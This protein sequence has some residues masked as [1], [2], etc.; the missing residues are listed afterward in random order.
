VTGLLLLGGFVA[1]LAMGA[2]PPLASPRPPVSQKQSAARMKAAS[3]APKIEGNKIVF[4]NKS[5]KINSNGRLEIGVDGTKLASIFYY[6]NTNFHSWIVTHD[7]DL[8]FRNV[9]FKSD[10]VR[11]FYEYSGDFPLEKA[12]AAEMPLGNYRQSV[13]L[14]ADGRVKVDMSWN[15]PAGMEKALKK[16][17]FFMTIPKEKVWQEKVRVD[18]KPYAFPNQDQYGFFRASPPRKITLF[19][20]RPDKSFVIEPQV[21]ALGLGEVRTNPR[22]GGN[23]CIRLWADKQQRRLTFLLDLRRGGLAES[24][25]DARGGIDFGKQDVLELPDAH[26]SKNLMRNPS[27]EQGLKDYYVWKGYSGKQESDPRKY[28]NFPYHEDDSIARFGDSSLR[29]TTLYKTYDRPNG[30]GLVRPGNITSQPVFLEP[31]TYTLSFYIRGDRPGKQRLTAW[32]PRPRWIVGRYGGSPFTPLDGAILRNVDVAQDWQRHSLVVK[33]PKLTPFRVN[34][35]AISET[36]EGHVWVDAVQVEQG[37]VATEFVTRPVEGRLLTSAPDNFLSAKECD[38]LNA[39]LKIYAAPGAVGRAKVAV[40]NFFSETVF[41]QEFRFKVDG[42][43]HAQIDLPLDGKLAKG[44]FV[45]KADYELDDGQT[46]YDHF[47]F[48]IMDF[49]QNR[50]RLKNMFAE[51]YGNPSAHPAFL[52]YLKRW[53]QIGIGAKCHMKFR[54]KELHEQY[55]RYGVALTDTFMRSIWTKRIDGKKVKFFSIRDD[56]DLKL[57]SSPNV[58]AGDFRKNNPTAELSD[59]YLKQFEHAAEI[60]ARKHPWVKVWQFGGEWGAKYPDFAGRTASDEEFAKFVRIQVAFFKGVK[61]GNPQAQVCQGD[62]CSMSPG[63]GIHLVDRLLTAIDGEIKY[64]LI[65]MHTYRVLPEYPDLDADTALFLKMLDKHGYSDTPIIFGEAMH[66]GPYAIPQLGVV[67][68]SWDPKVSWL[69]GA[70]SYDMGWLEKLSAAWRARSWLVGLKYQ[71]RL[72]SFMSAAM[73]NCFEIDVDLTPFAT[74]Q[75][76]NTLGNL[77]G[78]AHFKKDIRF[79]PYT[80]CYVFED[81]QRRPVAA[82]WGFHKNM[83]SGDM[84]PLQI[85]ANFTG[86]QLEVFD[87]MNARRSLVENAAGEAIFPVSPFP[88]FF[89]GQ[90]GGLSKLIASLENAGMVSGEGLTPITLSARPTLSGKM[91]LTAKNLYSREFAGTIVANQR[92]TALTIPPAGVNSLDLELPHP[93][94]PGQIVAE[95]IA[96]QIVAGN[97]NFPFEFK[98]NVFTSG[99]T[100]APITVDGHLDDWM[101]VLPITFTNRYVSGKNPRPIAAADFAGYFKTAWNEKGIWLCVAV[102]DDTFV[103][104]EYKIPASRWNNDSLQVYF[105]TL[106]DARLREK[107]GYDLNDYDY[108]V[109]PAA[110]GGSASTFR[111]RTPEWQLTLGPNAPKDKTFA[112]NIQTAFK[113]TA[114]GYVYEVF[115]PAKYVLPIKL[116]KGSAFG[117][118]LFV[119]DRDE[120]KTIDSALTLTPPG[121][122]GFNKPHLWPVMLLGE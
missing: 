86:Q 31:G 26:S 92:K 54:G 83:E 44:I 55:S 122:S 110:A 19:P 104:E 32:C 100:S 108:L 112:P 16:H 106:L 21:C 24:S 88:F 33:I 57:H 95:K 10:P 9:F 75:M 6:F 90:P 22:S 103:H 85:K 56:R 84:A 111:C 28:N 48:S 40:R 65:G 23:A 120:A 2:L 63:N 82:I 116:A 118:S 3:F 102:K 71:N 76:P 18:G 38:N 96:G 60:V 81:A 43:G 121:T 77:L 39:R 8:K 79:A 13:L 59:E 78:D 12:S 99:K 46:S 45:L 97:A 70:M 69:Y 30:L 52:R 68:V 49:L 117:F 47:R 62:P 42:R 14:L 114:D 89:R 34:F 93:L 11:G 25:R 36:G 119:N 109:L 15:V 101:H 20:D 41:Q 115:F 27:F 80:R 72:Q 64:D 105:D 1:E 50:H 35:N 87:L 98:F 51:C 37:S 58:L 91:R 94:V 5:L 61:K 7:R 73:T 113:K 29:I 4:G 53:R 67:S 74:Q 17:S 66:W 107:H